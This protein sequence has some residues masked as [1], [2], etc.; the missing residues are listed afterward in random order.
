[1]K[2]VNI[3][4][5][6]PLFI[7]AVSATPISRKEYIV[8]EAVEAAEK[9]RLDPNFVLDIIQAESSFRENLAVQD[10]VSVAYG[11]M[12]VTAPVW[13]QTMKGR[14]LSDAVQTRLNIE[15][16]CAYIATVKSWLEKDGRFSYPAL[17][18]AYNFGYGRL[19][20][21]GYDY[22]SLAWNHKNLTYRAIVRGEK[23]YGIHYFSSDIPERRVTVKFIPVESQDVLL[24]QHE[25]LKEKIGAAGTWNLSGRNKNKK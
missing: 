4:L 20:R 10:T 1:M 9:Y 14:P 22:K 18:V 15:C 23:K 19:K 16:G 8:R 7:G 6:I 11:P 21:A 25:I 5:L 13:E 24:A 12:Q 2:I 3:L 17:A